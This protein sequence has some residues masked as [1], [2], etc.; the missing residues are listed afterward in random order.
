MAQ[1]LSDLLGQLCLPAKI[2]GYSRLP[3]SVEKAAAPA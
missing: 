3:R 1:A 2:I